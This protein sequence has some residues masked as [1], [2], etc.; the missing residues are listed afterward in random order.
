[1]SAQ[2]LIVVG[3]PCVNTVAA[4][5]MGSPSDCSEGFTPGVA[6]IKLF[7]NGDSVAMLVAGYSAD[8]TVL[9]GEVLATRA[10]ELSGMESTV[11]GSTSS[12]ASISS[13]E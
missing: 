13:V 6:R 8:D 5:L 2:N 7:E 3:G 1:V 4:E 12:S 10:S 11:E 9:A